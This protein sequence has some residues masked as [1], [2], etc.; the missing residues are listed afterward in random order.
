MLRLVSTVTCAALGLA[1]FATPAAADS[2]SFGDYF[3]YGDNLANGF[4][5]VTDDG[6]AYHVT[7][8]GSGFQ[9]L[10]EGVPNFDWNG[11]FKGGVFVLYDGVAS[12]AVTI[13]FDSAL[14]SFTGFAAQ[15]KAFG[16]YTATLIAYDGS[17][18]VGSS[19]YTSANFGG[20]EGT[21][22]YFSVFA[23]AITSV[24]ISTSNDG[25][26]IGLGSDNAGIPEPAAWALMT[27]GLAC[28][29]AA[30]R[31]HRGLAAANR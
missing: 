14:S 31:L 17:T 3:F 23:P 4:S 18:Q 22:P 25:M 5:S 26:G 13:S 16:P 2:I 12:G 11:E 24:V 28:L 29:G 21:I 20:P 7:G 10:G 27:I 6:V 15:P 19:V 30:L 1:A 9:L 8:P